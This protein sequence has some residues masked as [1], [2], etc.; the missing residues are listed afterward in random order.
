[1]RALLWPFALSVV[2][3]SIATPLRSS[4][5]DLITPI[6]RTDQ[7]IT[8]VRS[9]T[10]IALDFSFFAHG[11]V[12]YAIWNESG[13]VPVPHSAGDF[14]WVWSAGTLLH[15]LGHNLSLC[16]FGAVIPAE[17]PE[18]L[19]VASDNGRVYKLDVQ[20]GVAIGSVDV[21]RPGCLAEDQVI[22]P[23]EVQLFSASSP[24]FQSAILA[25]R[26]RP[27]DL[28]FVC[29]HNGC[30]DHSGNQVICY[31]ASDL[32][33]RW[34]FNSTALYSMDSAE[35]G[36]EIDPDANIAYW[37]TNESS[38]GQNTLWAVQT[39]SG[40][41]LWSANAGAIR[42]RPML[43]PGAG[44][45]VYVAAVGDWVKR[46]DP[47]SGV[48]IWAYPT[49][50]PIV[51]NL[52][53]RV[54]DPLPIGICYTTA[55]GFLHGIMDNFPSP[56][57][58]W[59]AVSPGAGIKYT[60]GPAVA[61]VLD[62]G[63]LGRSDGLVQEVDVALGVP[64]A[65]APFGTAGTLCNPSLDVSGPGAP[66]TDR[67]MVSTTE[68]SISR[69]SIP[70]SAVNAVSGLP[71]HPESF[72][73]QNVPNPFSGNTRIEYRLPNDARVEVDV[74]D[75]EGHL[76]RTL[77]RDQLTAGPHEV[78]WNGLDDAGRSVT[79]GFY[80]CRLRATGTEGRSFE[81]VRKVQVVR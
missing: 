64:G 27:D 57:P 6:W 80:F 25:A 53:L 34:R 77:A 54:H 62:K 15:E 9:N 75:V 44:H 31:Y 38:P 18:A 47:Y 13:P 42:N 74:Y 21:R 29:T 40:G 35:D 17:G 30:E 24:G 26:G 72:L 52:S 10:G 46:R 79:S 69:F 2:V 66:A 7:G 8:P 28:V 12:L 81:R 36:C 14:K 55:D 59:P 61:P 67:L 16:H 65:V 1:M 23:P 63:Y 76:V 20:T 41:L 58:M 11:P 32:T 71:S 73:S 39:L 50:S 22:A 49:G 45:G 70:W 3:A 37:G 4:A 33:E 60:T 78:S 19:F 51:G 5:Q 43:G 68:G 48:E 56:V